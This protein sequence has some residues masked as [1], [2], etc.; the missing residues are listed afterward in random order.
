MLQCDN[1]SRNSRQAAFTRRPTA[2]RENQAGSR[3]LVGDVESAH[4]F[5]GQPRRADQQ[6]GKVG[7]E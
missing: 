6:I 2:P 3:K 7:Q 4:Q 5:A 1:Q